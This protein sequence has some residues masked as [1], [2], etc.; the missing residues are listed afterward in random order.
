MHNS[1]RSLRS[2]R[3]NRCRK[4][5]GRRAARAGLAP[6]APRRRKVAAPAA[7]PRLCEQRRVTRRYEG[8]CQS[9]LASYGDLSV[10]V[11]HN[12]AL[13]MKSR[14]LSHDKPI[15]EVLSKGQVW[16]NPV[17]FAQRVL[18]LIRHDFS[19]FQRGVPLPA[20]ASIYGVVPVNASESSYLGTGMPPSGKRMTAYPAREDVQP[21]TP[22][23]RHSRRTLGPTA[24]LQVYMNSRL[25]TPDDIPACLVLR[26]QTRENAISAE[27]LA[28]MG[29]TAESWPRRALGCPQRATSA[30]TIGRSS[31]TASVRTLLRGGNGP[32]PSSRIRESRYRPAPAWPRRSPS[33]NC[34]PRTSVLGVRCG[35][36]HTFPWVLPSPRL[37]VHG[38]RKSGRR[39]D[40]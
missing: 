9:T 5:E 40:S 20:V 7:R 36:N 14:G 39:R 22:V 6:C 26:G 3:S 18:S 37:G 16:L 21:A 10:A 28:A 15:V 24:N 25:A 12:V 17:L 38:D 33:Q 19:T 11:L 13:L 34:R 4:S 2:L 1:L 30:P 29:I 35:P 23:G 32:G 8:R 31:D 27:R